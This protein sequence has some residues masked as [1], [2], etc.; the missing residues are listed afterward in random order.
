MQISNDAINRLH[1]EGFIEF[2]CNENDIIKIAK[3]LGEPI[4]SRLNSGV[5]DY[6]VPKKNDEAHYNS[7]SKLYGL[8]SL[9]FHTDG[10]YF[11][12]P[13]KY[14]ILRYVKGIYKPTPTHI[15]KIF[16]QLSSHNIDKLKKEIWLVKG[17]VRNFYS[18]IISNTLVEN[19]FVIR[20]DTGCMKFNGDNTCIENLLLNIK[21]E[22][23]YCINWETNKTVIINN[24]KVLHSRPKVKIEENNYRTL[25]RIMVYA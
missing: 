25:Q 1:H 10:A 16:N 22:N 9:P 23:I 19:E 5:I 6:I 20:F 24:W 21:K 17:R 14:I 12:I 13:P 2:Y 18:S 11:E 8:N 4:S 7:L 3:N 15:M